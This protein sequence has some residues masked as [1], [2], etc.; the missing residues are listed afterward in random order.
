[1]ASIAEEVLALVDT[2]PYALPEGRLGPITEALEALRG[3]PEL[4]DAIE[5]L[6]RLAG[7]FMEQGAAKVAGSILSLIEA[8]ATSLRS[9]RVRMCG[10]DEAEVEANERLSRF[11][12][13]PLAH[14][15][16]THRPQRDFR[17]ALLAN[18]GESK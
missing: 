16:P 3:C 15:A 7:Y 2:E 12:A 8:Q 6:A 13:T 5:E 11:T 17:I 1:M 18:R 10:L 14:V 4:A 9:L